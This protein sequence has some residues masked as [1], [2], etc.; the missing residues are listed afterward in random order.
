MASRALFGVRLGLGLGLGLALGSLSLGCVAPYDGSNIQLDFATAVQTAAR[1]GQTPQPLQPPEG[2]HYELYAVDQVFRTDPDGTPILDDDGAPILDQAYLFAV[3]QFEIRPV[4]DRSSPCFIEL[5]DTQFPGL[6]VTQFQTAVT[7]SIRA[8]LGLDHDP[9]PFESGLPSD[10]VTDLLN[11]RRRV[12]NLGL[13]EPGLKAVTSHEAVRYAATTACAA[14]YAADA[15]PDPTCT[16]EVSNAQRLRACRA[17][18]AAHPGFYEGSD[19][20]FTL[21]LNGRYLGMVQGTNPINGGRVGGSSMFVDVNLVDRDA[22]VINWQ[23]DDVNDDG[24][25]DFPVD[26]APQ[27][28]SP[29]GYL[30]MA[31]TP[32]VISRGVTTVPLRHPNDPSIKADLAIVP[33]LG[34]DDVHF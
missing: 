32:R 10:A 6:H 20:V 3:T 8:Q 28:R 33:N 21:P 23:Y 17:V 15:I 19:K 29:V 7:A 18:W 30:Y 2:T 24:T 25:P 13:L 4:I 31:G 11:A 14:S 16:D 9:D 5:E 27:E 26:L 12:D 1:P 22:Y 34:H